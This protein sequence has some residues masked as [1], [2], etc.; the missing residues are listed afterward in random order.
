MTKS[1][2]ERLN[3]YEI[4]KQ[5]PH[6]YDMVPAAN[7]LHPP[8]LPVFKS[9]S[10]RN[11]YLMNY[12]SRLGRH[13]DWDIN[14][15]NV[16]RV[17]DYNR[18]EEWADG[19]CR[20]VYPPD[21]DEAKRHSS[22]WAMRN[23]N[24]HNV[25]ILKKSCLGV[26]VCSRRCVLPNGDSV[27]LRPAICDK[28]R[29][30]Q[31]GM[32]TQPIIPAMQ[33]ATRNTAMQGPLR[34]PGHAFL[35]SHGTRHFLPGYCCPCGPFDC[36]CPTSPRSGQEVPQTSAAAPDMYPPIHHPV[37]QW[38]QTPT[39]EREDEYYGS[40][41]VDYG[42]P[43]SSGYPGHPHDYNPEFATPPPLEIFQTASGS[44]IDCHSQNLGASIVPADSAG[45]LDVYQSQHQ[46]QSSPPTLL[47]LGSGTIKE[48]SPWQPH[49]TSQNDERWCD[50]L[51]ELDALT[52]TTTD[53]SLT[54]CSWASSVEMKTTWQSHPN[55]SAHKQWTSHDYQSQEN[56]QQQ[57]PVTQACPF[58]PQCYQNVRDSNCTYISIQNL[59]LN[60]D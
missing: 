15:S 52:G 18:F 1:F 35:A 16:P 53:S 39:R 6:V 5:T 11:D 33:W 23:T 49:G 27:H 2:N 38:Y 47:D 19:H 21:S 30:K 50:A 20:L 31:Q 3:A 55:H 4:V 60:M 46:Y 56:K 59:V 48:E 36:V 58:Q 45:H 22:G 34:L 12:P 17:V 24:N 51:A 13:Q 10:E 25:H 54:D 32:H 8:P 9:D 44:I 42:P 7:L 29:K 37:P 43:P 14:D 26:L 28:A 41:G 57:T 40:S